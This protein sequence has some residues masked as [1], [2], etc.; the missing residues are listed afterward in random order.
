MV[1]RGAKFNRVTHQFNYRAALVMTILYR[2]S[3]TD[4]VEP[5]LS[6]D[7]CFSN[8]GGIQFFDHRRDGPGYRMR[9]TG[10]HL[11][12]HHPTQ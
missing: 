5:D 10:N 1:A 6:W 3:S 12:D 9:R 2:I 4:G 7:V 11:I 8:H